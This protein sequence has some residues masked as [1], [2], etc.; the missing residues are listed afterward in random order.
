MSE[1]ETIFSSQVKYEGIFSFKEFYRFCHDWLKEEVELDITEEKYE[2]K[3]LADS[4]DIIVE[5]VGTR[6]VTDYFKYELKISFTLRRIQ[7]V[8]IQEG[9]VKV[10]MNQGQIKLSLKGNLIRDYDGK[11]EGTALKKFM[12]SVYEKWVIAAR[13][14]EYED[15]LSGDCDEFLNQAKAYLDLEGK[16]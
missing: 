2:E 4:K 10:K 7:N 16:K 6:K 3:I 12:R 15:K 8:E 1:K 5:W 14:E 9:N 11:F 13:I